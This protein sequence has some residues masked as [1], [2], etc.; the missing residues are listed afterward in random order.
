MKN[1]SRR[2]FLYCSAA[3]LST[4]LPARTLLSFSG[5]K[6]SRSGAADIRGRVFKGDGPDQ[7][8]KWSKEGFLYKKLKGNKVV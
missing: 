7:I 8:W 3:F 2:R 5:K 1:I 4:T 6:A